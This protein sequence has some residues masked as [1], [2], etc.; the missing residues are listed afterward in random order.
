LTPKD[1][2]ILYV[3]R[4]SNGSRVERLHLDVDGDFIDDWPGGFFPERL[5]ELM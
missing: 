1:V 3:S 2:S 5:R 4:G